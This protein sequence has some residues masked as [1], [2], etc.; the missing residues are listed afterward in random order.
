MNRR[1]IRHVLAV[2]AA[3]VLPIP[4][5]LLLYSVVLA[6]LTVVLFDVYYQEQFV[7]LGEVLVIGLSSTAPGIIFIG[8]VSVV[9]MLGKRES[10]LAVLQDARPAVGSARLLMAARLA[11]LIALLVMI[12]S[13]LVWLVCTQAFLLAKWSGGDGLAAY[14][15]QVRL[16]DYAFVPDITLIM[17]LYAFFMLPLAVFMLW[18]LINARPG[19]LRSCWHNLPNLACC[20][21]VLAGYWLVASFA[22]FSFFE[23]G[24]PPALLFG[25]LALAA[26]RAT[27]HGPRS[28]PARST[29]KLC[30]AAQTPQWARQRSPLAA[31]PAAP[32]R[33]RY[34]LDSL[35]YRLAALQGGKFLRGGLIINHD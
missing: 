31:L 7:G 21:I 18:S 22:G 27:P 15:Q 10:F 32:D 25:Y 9:M 1:E 30:P 13:M 14:L 16:E 4:R 6:F 29:A 24:N 34:M 17:L 33:C 8:L 5:I 11:S 26:A 12:V 2:L 28:A 35:R 23:P 20:A 3:R 19:Y